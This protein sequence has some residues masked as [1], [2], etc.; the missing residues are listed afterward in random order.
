ML[1]VPTSLRRM[2]SQRS[3]SADRDCARWVPRCRTVK[4]SSRTP[5][6]SISRRASSRAARL[7]SRRHAFSATA[8]DARNLSIAPP[9]AR[10]PRCT[11]ICRDASAE[12]LTFT[13][14][15]SAFTWMSSSCGCDC[16]APSTA[17]RPDDTTRERSAGTSLS[18]VMSSFRPL[19]CSGANRTW[20]CIARAMAPT[21]S[22]PTASASTA[23]SPTA[24]FSAAPSSTLAD[25]AVETP[26]R[27]DSRRLRTRP[28]RS[29]ARSSSLGRASPSGTAAAAAAIAPQL[30]DRPTSRSLAALFASSKLSLLRSITSSRRQ[31]GLRESLRGLLAAAGLRLGPGPLLRRPLDRRIRGGEFPECRPR[32]EVAA[33]RERGGRGHGL[34][35]GRGRP[36]VR[37]GGSGVP[38]FRG[39]GVPGIRGVPGAWKSEIPCGERKEFR[40]SASRRPQHTPA[41]PLLQPIIGCRTTY[42]ARAIGQR[43]GS[44]L[45]RPGA[46]SRRRHRSMMRWTAL[47]S[48]SMSR[49]QSLP[50][51]ST[52]SRAKVDLQLSR[53][54]WEIL[55][56]CRSSR[57]VNSLRVM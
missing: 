46:G 18:S 22:S 45:A 31:E 1:Q 29:L 54:S 57:M 30:L 26:M 48:I 6:R 14:S 51:A 7:C 13:R 55:P 9:T 12:Q 37:R 56:C 10:T 17:G 38:G 34:R 33:L 39:S 47:G 53:S 3:C 5:W 19:S 21:S 49:W 25:A 2:P 15:L 50:L 52:S 41:H 40:S 32:A 8:R 35:G 16:I 43:M 44:D 23:G 42:R 4:R 11:R 24:S 20:R 36:G 27:S 28:R